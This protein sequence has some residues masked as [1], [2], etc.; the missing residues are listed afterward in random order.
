VS[1]RH[2]VLAAMVF[3]VA[4]TFIDQTIVAIAI[5]S[6]V[7]HRVR[8][9][10]PDR[11]ADRR[12]ARGAAGGAAGQRDRRGRTERGQPRAA[13]QIVFYVM[14]AVLVVNF[15]V[16]RLW[17]PRS[18]VETAGEGAGYAPAPA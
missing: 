10:R 4:M 1:N 6:V 18:R 9:R 15:V 13:T 8:D 12:Q 2:L 11:R 7:L 16:A 3:A 14:A 5:P 17:L